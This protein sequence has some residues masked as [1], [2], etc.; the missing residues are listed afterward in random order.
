MCVY[1]FSTRMDCLYMK[2]PELRKYATSIGVKNPQ[3]MTK[4]A[5]ED[6][7][8]NME[9]ERLAKCAKPAVINLNEMNRKQLVEVGKEYGLKTGRVT[10]ATLIEEIRNKNKVIPIHKLADTVITNEQ[11]EGTTYKQLRALIPRTVGGK[12]VCKEALIELAKQYT[13]S[14]DGYELAKALEEGVDPEEFSIELLHL[15]AKSLGIESVG[16]KSRGRILS[17][18]QHESEGFF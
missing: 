7:I 11:V 10:K 9:Q 18:V 15:Y 17:E 5:L 13:I 2:V 12:N 14:T 1:N 4:A 6:A 16:Q 8:F 3:K